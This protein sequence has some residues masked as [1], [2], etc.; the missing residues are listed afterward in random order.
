MRIVLA[1][2]QH[3]GVVT[4]TGTGTLLYHG[5][6]LVVTNQSWYRSPINR[7]AVL[8]RGVSSLKTVHEARLCIE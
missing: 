7:T 1:L 3:N 2:V 4:M 5:S 6:T 8:Y